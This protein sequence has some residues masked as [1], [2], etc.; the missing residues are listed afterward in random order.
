V[1]AGKGG[2]WLFPFLMARYNLDPSR[3]AMVVSATAPAL[4][5]ALL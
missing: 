2:A 1:V 3:T 5:G 4:R